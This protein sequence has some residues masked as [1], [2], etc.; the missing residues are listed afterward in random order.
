MNTT[1]EHPVVQDTAAWSASQSGQKQKWPSNDAQ[2]SA[3]EFWADPNMAI[4]ERVSAIVNG[5]CGLTS[6]TP[7][8]P[9]ANQ[10][11]AAQAKKSAA[12]LF[13]IMIHPFSAIEG[14]IG[15]YSSGAEQALCAVEKGVGANTICKVGAPGISPATT[16]TQK[17]LAFSSAGNVL[18]GEIDEGSERGAFRHVLWIADMTEKFGEEDA[19]RIADCHE[20]DMPFNP[21]QRLFPDRESADRAVDRHNNIIGFALGNSST[22]L[23]TKEHAFE[24][25]EVMRKEGLFVARKRPDGMYEIHQNKIS[26]DKYN[27]MWQQLM[28]LDEDGLPLV[29]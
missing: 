28:F 16:A 21:E 9:G 15:R 10:A 22:K 6:P 20:R 11:L 19:S 24:A 5:L 17:A 27:R 29:P 23:T 26:E 4:K 8:V 1:F 14:D 13:S 7:D 25:L 3:S 18:D 12:R 2:S